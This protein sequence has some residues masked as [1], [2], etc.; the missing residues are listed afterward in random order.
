MAW[1]FEPKGRSL[2]EARHTLPGGVNVGRGGWEGNQGQWGR[3]TLPKNVGALLKA[4]L[5]LRISQR[6]KSFLDQTQGSKPH[7][8]SHRMRAWEE[9]ET[10]WAQ[11]RLAGKAGEAL[12]KPRGCREDSGKQGKTPSTGSLVS[13]LED[14][15]SGSPSP[16]QRRRK[17]ASGGGVA[18]AQ[19][20]TRL[21]KIKGHLMGKHSC[22]RD[23]W[24]TEPQ[25]E[26]TRFFNRMDLLRI[27]Y[28]RDKA[29][30]FVGILVSRRFSD[31]THNILVS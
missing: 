20:W 15:G 3:G 30:H 5:W 19:R 26:R 10:G 28:T 13:G 23:W 27:K 4:S 2:E 14:S 12:W 29:F 9:Q 1:G 8:S 22:R 24:H 11:P 7:G 17:A 25:R 18:G 16:K 6:L 31:L 21:Q